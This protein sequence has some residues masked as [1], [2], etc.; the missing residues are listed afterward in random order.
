MN[1]QEMNKNFKFAISNI[2]WNKEDDDYVYDLMKK[3]DFSGLEIAPT[4][5]FPNQPYDHTEELLS[6][7]DKLKSVYDF[8]FPSIQSIWYGR[9]E[10]LFGTALERQ[11]LL[12]YTKRAID[13]FRTIN[14]GNFVL[15]CPKNRNRPEGLSDEVAIDFFREIGNYAFSCGGRIGLEANPAIYGTNFVNDTVSALEIIERVAS[16]GFCLNLDIGTMIENGEDMN[17][18][19]GRSCLIS[20]VHISEPKLALIQPRE[21]HK[22]LLNFLMEENY[23]GYI[24]IEMGKVESLEQI[25]GVL[26]YMRGF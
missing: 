20:H 22:R 4:K 25:E 9:Q 3:Y 19:K 16:K 15:G 7:A 5:I 6:W 14:V 12:G 11:R 17:F 13:C 21:L 1:I 2:A 18:L 8:S 23:G 26:K 24:S 10:Q